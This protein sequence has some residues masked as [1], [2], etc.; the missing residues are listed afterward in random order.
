MKPSEI[1]G[2]ARNDQLWDVIG[3]SLGYSLFSWIRMLG[4]QPAAIGE[5]Q[6]TKQEN[7]EQEAILIDLKDRTPTP[8]TPGCPGR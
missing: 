8:I 4:A 5:R 2:Q 1:P 7:S 3:I 6:R